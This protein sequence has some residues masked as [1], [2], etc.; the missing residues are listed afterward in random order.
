ME[1][2]L[3]W[4]LGSWGLAL[5]V[6]L[7]ALL[8]VKRAWDETYALEG[9]LA[10]VKHERETVGAERLEF[11]VRLDAMKQARER[12][13]RRREEMQKENE[14]LTQRLVAALQREADAKYRLSER[15]QDRAR[16]WAEMVVA[17][18]GLSEEQYQ[19]GFAVGE[20]HALW[21]SVLALLK[22]KRELVVQQLADQEMLA[23]HNAAMIMSSCAGGL[24]WIDDALA[25]LV[26]MRQRAVAPEQTAA[27][28]AVA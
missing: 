10:R 25:E 4:V 27:R 28:K 11:S 12:L 3:L 14:S 24:E 2:S 15:E 16:A 7:V 23:Q 17:V 9:E 18:D 19:T 22:L 8:L 5:V 26:T 20:D 13:E 1:T 21:R 6:I